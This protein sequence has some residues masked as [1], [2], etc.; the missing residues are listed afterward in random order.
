MK[1]LKGLRPSGSMVVAIIALVVA[2]TGTAF[3]A[4]TIT[5]N[6]IVNGAVSSKKVKDRSLKSKD[7]SNQ[8]KR[9]LAG[10][11]GPQGPAGPAGPQ[12]Q[13]GPASPAEYT[14][15]QW[16]TIHRNT[17]GSPDV[18][19]EGATA[20]PPFGDGALAMSVEGTPRSA[21]NSLAEQ[22]TFGN[23][24]DFAG[25]PLNGISEVGFHVYQTGENNGRGTPNMPAIKLEIDPNLTATSSN[26]STLQVL[27]PNSAA[28]QWSGY[29]DGTEVAA[30]PSGSGWIMSGAAGTATGCLLADPCTFDEMQTALAD[31]GD[32]AS[33]LTVAV[34]KGRDYA[35]SGMVD[36]LRINGTV[37][38]FEPF[39]VQETTP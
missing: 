35:W 27:V 31:G 3:A 36:G 2:A 37:Y 32:E 15:P 25:D 17:I 14:N 10:P 28:N 20:T 5:T 16:A 29:I 38:D 39:G 23:E 12:G 21:N 8:A 1:Y 26:F 18:A 11:A 33:V 9:Q 34:G 22:A 24:T 19:L 4:A 30:S 6:D 7:L 13:P